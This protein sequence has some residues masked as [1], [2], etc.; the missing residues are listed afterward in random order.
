MAKPGPKK[1]TKQSRAHK[2]KRSKAMIGKKNPAYKDGRRSFRR[3]AGCKKG[4][5]KIV[6]HKN[7]NRKDNRR[8][9]LVILKGK[10]A[11]A[12][13]NSTHERAHAK[14]RGAGRPKGSKSKTTK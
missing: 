11:G 1:N 5:K 7:H 3:I 2:A 9:N 14:D 10:R 6:H 13:T 8:S 4:D 12:K